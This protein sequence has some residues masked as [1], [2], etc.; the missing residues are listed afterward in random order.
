LA[1]SLAAAVVEEV[2]EAAAVVEAAFHLR[3]RH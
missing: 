2:V 1:G 3:T